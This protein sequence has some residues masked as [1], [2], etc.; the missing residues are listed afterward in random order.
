MKAFKAPGE[1]GSRRQDVLNKGKK[2]KE[3]E[4]EKNRENIA[5]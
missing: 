2:K 5:N 1:A 3:E 4:Y